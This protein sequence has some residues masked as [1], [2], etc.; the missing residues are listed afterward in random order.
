[1]LFYT[2]KENTITKILAQQAA[3]DMI[4][5]GGIILKEIYKHA[6][7]NLLQNRCRDISPLLIPYKRIYLYY[8]NDTYF[9]ILSPKKNLR[10][11]LN[12]CKFTKN[13]LLL[14]TLD[15]V[16]LLPVHG[17]LFNT[18]QPNNTYQQP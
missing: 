5:H 7:R 12:V 16:K 9:L 18:Y 2:L 8:S 13:K 10:S 6:Y 11:Q 3:N 17:Q 15:I 4:L 14:S 1:M